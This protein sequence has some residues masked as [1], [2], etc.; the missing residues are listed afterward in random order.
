MREDA[1]ER[2]EITSGLGTFCP[3]MIDGGPPIQEVDVRAGVDGLNTSVKRLVTSVYCKDSN[4][5]R[6]SRRWGCR[7]GLMSEIWL[8]RTFADSR[9]ADW[10]D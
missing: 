3:L 8:K 1:T 9:F 7:R 10:R 6:R 2:D 5:R 4:S